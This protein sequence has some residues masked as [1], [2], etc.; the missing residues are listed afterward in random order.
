MTCCG[1]SMRE[2]H[3]VSYLTMKGWHLRYSG[4]E[5][6]KEGFTHVR[7]RRHTCGCCVKEEMTE[8]FSLDDAYDAQM[9]KDDAGA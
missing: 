1:L 6:T 8:V 2:V 3:M 9:E 4:D 7:E 5:W